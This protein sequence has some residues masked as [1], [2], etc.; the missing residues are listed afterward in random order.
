MKKFLSIFQ[1]FKNN[2]FVFYFF[3]GLI[4]LAVLIPLIF[5][6]DWKDEEVININERHEEHIKKVD[7]IK[8]SID[9]DSVIIW[10]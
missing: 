5:I 8:N 10:N 1:T 4:V 3:G 7:S 2:R 9:K 6:I